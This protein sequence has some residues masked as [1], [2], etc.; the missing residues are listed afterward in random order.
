MSAIKTLCTRGNWHF[1]VRDGN[2]DFVY[3]SFFLGHNDVPKGR[4]ITFESPVE[5][6]IPIDIWREISEAWQKSD[7]YS[8]KKLDNMTKEGQKIMEAFKILKEKE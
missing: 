3:L 5:I 1:F 6:R 4:N 7:W 2:Y 8:N